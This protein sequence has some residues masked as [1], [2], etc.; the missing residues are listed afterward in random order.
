MHAHESKRSDGGLLMKRWGMS[1]AG[2]ATAAALILGG[3]GI[4]YADSLEVQADSLAAGVT[5]VALGSIACNTG[6]EVSVDL[7]IDRGGNAATNTYQGGSTVTFSKTSQ[8]NV[9]ASPPSP[10]SVVLRSDWASLPQNSSE[11]SASSSSS[12]AVQSA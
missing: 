1:I 9:S 8:T 3:G 2:V 4:A 5:N 6:A 12:V 10:S 11:V 7:Y